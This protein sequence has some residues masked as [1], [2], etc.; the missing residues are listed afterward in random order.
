MTFSVILNEFVSS[1]TDEDSCNSNF[2]IY[3]YNGFHCGNT[4]N[5]DTGI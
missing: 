4:Q 5:S 2:Y 3:K 1:L